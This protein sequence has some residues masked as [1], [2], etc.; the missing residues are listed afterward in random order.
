MGRVK[1]VIHSMTAE[2][3]Q[4]PRLLNASRRK[5]IAQGSGAQVADVNRLI[6]QFDMVKKMMKQVSDMSRGGRQKMPFKMPFPM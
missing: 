6:K 5:R 3:R 1:A 4:N 2:E